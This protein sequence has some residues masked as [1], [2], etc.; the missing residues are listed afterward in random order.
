MSALKDHVEHQLRG[1]IRVLLNRVLHYK[2]SPLT[3]A[4]LMEMFVDPDDV[5]AVKK[6]GKLFSHARGGGFG[7]NFVEPGT[8]NS[9]RLWIS[10]VDTKSKKAFMHPDYMGE[11]FFGNRDGEA[12]QR[13]NEWI[14][15]RLDASRQFGRV[16]A[17]L[18][19]LNEICDDATQVRF[20]FPTLVALAGSNEGLQDFADKIRDHKAPKRLPAI[21]PGL[22]EWVASSEVTVTKALLLPNPASQP[23]KSEEPVTL[24]LSS[25]TLEKLPWDEKRLAPAFND[26]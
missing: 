21:H 12:M 18:N 20:V 14:T 3:H 11:R 7:H 15:W 24:E 5:E 13:L 19:R 10:S 4:D 16:A 2:K 22:R 1:S 25:Y 26:N 9:C 23:R 8:D 6:A 17:V